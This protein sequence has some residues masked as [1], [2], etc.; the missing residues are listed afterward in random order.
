M[1]DS[2]KLNQVKVLS[3]NCQMYVHMCSEMQGGNTGQKGLCAI[4]N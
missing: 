1:I 3:F 2:T 4:N